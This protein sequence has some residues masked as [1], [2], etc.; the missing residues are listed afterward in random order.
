MFKFNWYLKDLPKEFNSGTVFSCFSSGGGSSMGY[1]LAGFD[2]IGCNEI[3]DKMMGDYILN[4]NPQFPY[5]EDIRT[6]KERE[7]LPKELY[8]LDILEGSPPCTS[9]SMAGVRERDWGKERSYKEG[10]TLQ[11]LDD[12]FFEYLEVVDKLKPKIVIAENVKGITMGTAK[13]YVINIMQVLDKIGYYANFYVLDSSKMGLPQKRERF[14]IVGVRKDLAPLIDNNLKSDF[15]VNY[16]IYG[17][18]SDEAWKKVDL[19]KV[20]VYL[21]KIDFGPYT[22]PIPLKEAFMGT[23]PKTPKQNYIETRFGDVMCNMDKPLNTIVTINRYWYD[24]ENLLDL[25]TL[26]N[27]GS[28]PHDY[29]WVKGESSQ[30]VHYSVGMSVPPIMMAWVVSKIK[31]QY[32]NKITKK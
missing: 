28:W 11:T 22:E 15:N 13:K 31:E 21:P 25:P 29:K 24:R 16:N 1:K 20:P 27:C 30:R 32:L 3:D 12:L 17:D 18:I 9:F 2:V 14:F 6:F 10:G 8:N 5:K 23:I 26:K 7:D 19:N 4:F